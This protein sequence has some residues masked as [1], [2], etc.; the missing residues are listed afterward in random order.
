MKIME[1]L[2]KHSDLWLSLYC[3]N[4]NLGPI[5]NMEILGDEINKVC[6]YTEKLKFLELGLFR[7]EQSYVFR[8]LGLLISFIKEHDRTI[9]LT[10]K[11]STNWSESLAEL[12]LFYEQLRQKI[13]VTTSSESS[14]ES[15]KCESNKDEISEQSS[16][17]L[18]KGLVGSKLPIAT[19]SRRR[20]SLSTI[21]ESSMFTPV[22]RSPLINFISKQKETFSS[23]Y[24]NSNLST[25]KEVPITPTSVAAVTKRLPFASPIPDSSVTQASTQSIEDNS[26]QGRTKLKVSPQ[27]EFNENGCNKGGGSIQQE[28]NLTA[29]VED[30]D[31]DGDYKEVKHSRGFPRF[32]PK[33]FKAH[34]HDAHAKES[35]TG[36][37]AEVKPR[38]GT[39]NKIRKVFHSKS[40]SSGASE[41]D[42][43]NHS[44]SIKSS[45]ASKLK[46]S[47]SHRSKI[48]TS[49]GDS[50][51]SSSSNLESPQSG[52]P[53]RRSS[54]FRG[55]RKKNVSETDGSSKSRHLSFRGLKDSS[56]EKLGKLSGKLHRSSS[57][58]SLDKNS[59]T[60][61][62]VSLTNYS[63][64][65]DSDSREASDEESNFISES[66]RSNTA[67]QND[68]LMEHGVVRNNGVNGE[69]YH[70]FHESSQME[71]KGPA[72]NSKNYINQETETGFMRSTIAQASGNLPYVNSCETAGG[73]NM[74]GDTGN[75]RPPVPPKRMKRKVSAASF[76]AMKPRSSYRNMPATFQGEKNPENVNPVPAPQRIFE[77]GHFV[78]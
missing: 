62:D 52:L 23:N 66:A 32:L 34:K 22:G 77:N 14:S 15:T 3:V 68:R 19:E 21:R 65:G 42:K 16:I 37:S 2:L 56:R 9:F 53:G 1:W 54:S 31:S 57:K 48:P 41:V 69:L 49:K 61:D 51:I 46:R 76:I 6:S 20:D 71:I 50:E 43:S 72:Q 60:V 10:D 25:K 27:T 64:K 58:S 55:F 75:L 18:P 7:R 47:L 74:N 13:L 30:A 39:R 36:T 17:L 44:S 38:M 28:D 33:A 59:G 5:F 78:G 4:D 11:N 45:I 70:N 67:E 29:D 8:S 40:K 35:S 12:T 26:S 63:T 24:S 73:H